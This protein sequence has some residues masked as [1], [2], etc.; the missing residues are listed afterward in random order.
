MGLST[1]GELPLV[2]ALMPAYNYGHFLARTL[3][4]FVA[5]DY[6]P[7]R[8]EI[9][10]V[11]DGSTDDTPDILRDYGERHPGRFRVV[12]QENG[13]FIAATNATF[14]H[15]R[16]DLLAFL[17]ADD[18]WPPTKTQEQVA[19]LQQN[20][21]VG[22]VYSDTELIDPY[23]DVVRA[24]VWEWYQQKPLRGDRT[25]TPLIVA[26]SGNP[27]LNSTIMVRA[28]LADR[29]APIPDGVP[30]VDWWVAAR[31]AQVAGLEIT[32]SRVGYRMH[33]ENITLGATGQRA[34]REVLK[35]VQMRRQL[36]MRG[37]ADV[38]T[39]RE[40]LAAWRSLEGGATHTARLA[41]TVFLPLP[42][43]T[44]EERDAGARHAAAA[45]AATRAGQWEQAL[46]ERILA[47]VHD[48]WDADSREWIADLLE[49]AF[50]DGPP[51]QPLEG[52]R[53]RV[54]LSFLTELEAE[55][56][57]LAAYV[58]Q[59]DEGDDMTLAIDGAGLPEADA[60]ARLQL[61]LE[62]VGLGLD[63]LPDVLLVAQEPR[64]LVTLE[65][66]SRADALLSRRPSRLGAPVFPPDRVAALRERLS[67]A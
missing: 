29:F 1:P 27:A 64:K 23:D 19:V 5:Q 34:V 21:E 26:S 28:S 54:V 50:Y 38:V 2:S 25:L 66:E 39:T 4:S 30:Y 59:I 48:P 57:M 67:G 41:G 14:A 9:V 53:S 16:G 11:D 7:D 12:R 8:L 35:A 45:V 18:L 3:D 32:P 47:V 43:L 40:L 37:A 61:V 31:V 22:L 55:P 46:R 42:E 62:R 56:Q 20:P 10:V 13:G 6:P 44:P 60:L 49:A 33:G 52:A 58:E 63:G 24:S 51:P 17:D 36:L 65:L 15:A